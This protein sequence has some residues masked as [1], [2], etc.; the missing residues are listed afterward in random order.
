MFDRSFDSLFIANTYKLTSLILGF[1]FEVL[2]INQSL[3]SPIYCQI[4]Y[5]F[6]LG[7]KVHAL[8]DYI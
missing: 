5:C 3:N 4:G 7:L 8:R 2:I 1:G 6:D